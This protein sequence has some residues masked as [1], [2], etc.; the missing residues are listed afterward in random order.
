MHVTQKVMSTADV[1]SVFVFPKRKDM[2]KEL[3]FF[4][5]LYKRFQFTKIILQ[6]RRT[7][8]QKA[9]I[10]SVMQSAGK[11]TLYP[12]TYLLRSNSVK[13][14]TQFNE[15]T[16]DHIRHY[17]LQSLVR[18]AHLSCQQ[19]GQLISSAWLLHYFLFLMLIQ[20]FDE[21]VINQSIGI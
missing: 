18:S 9:D 20:Y 11:H 12:S 3:F 2:T 13:H 1:N 4:I 6:F 14:I 16:K 7:F 15:C 8:P 5:I 17:Y 10:R 19:H 21:A